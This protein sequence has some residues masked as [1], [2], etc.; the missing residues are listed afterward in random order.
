M[1]G[2]KRLSTLAFRNSYT[3]L[4]KTIIAVALEELVV[5]VWLIRVGL[6]RG[7][8]GRTEGPG[9]RE[10]ESKDGCV[11]EYGREKREVE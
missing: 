11:R 10:R 6:E 5:V 2:G 8:T 3:R 1:S 9:T 4:P 7:E